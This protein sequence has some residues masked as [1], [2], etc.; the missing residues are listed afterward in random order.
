MAP[1]TGRIRDCQRKLPQPHTNMA[2]E[3]TALRT[4]N[5]GPARGGAD[6]RRGGGRTTDSRLDGI[7][8]LRFPNRRVRADSR[9][10]AAH[11]QDAATALDV[12]AERGSIR[13]LGLDRALVHQ[14]R[15]RGHPVSA[16]TT[17][18]C[19]TIHRRGVAGDAWITRS[20][21]SGARSRRAGAVSSA[22]KLSPSV[23]AARGP[24]RFNAMDAHEKKIKVQDPSDTDGR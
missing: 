21:L 23:V 16:S 19:S 20:N 11:R 13:D 22:P 1:G 9:L 6:A 4:A 3:V 17:R 10:V 7:C 14:E 5:V 2:S 12:V 18:S 24:M 15:S 8:R